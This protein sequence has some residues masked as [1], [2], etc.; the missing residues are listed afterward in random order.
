MEA[1][2][3]PADGVQ[4]RVAAAEAPS[5]DLVGVEHP[6]E[7]FVDVGAECDEVLVPLPRDPLGAVLADTRS[8]S[9]T[10][11]AERRGPSMLR[12]DSDAPK[13]IRQNLRLS[14]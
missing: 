13:C 11:P 2:A 14:R 4:V 7:V 9:D 10:A 3:E 8:T 6:V 12:S 1:P 5:E